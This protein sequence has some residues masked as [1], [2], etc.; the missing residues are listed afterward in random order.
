[1]SKRA[2]LTKAGAKLLIALTVFSLSIATFALTDSY[3]IALAALFVG[4]WTWSV[5]TFG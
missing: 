5:L 2:E 3:W 4:A 1:M